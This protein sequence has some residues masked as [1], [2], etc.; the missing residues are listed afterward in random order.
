MAIAQ[1]GEQLADFKQKSAA[2][3][4]AGAWILHPSTRDFLAQ[5]EDSAGRTFTVR[6]DP[7][8]MGRVAVAPIWPI[9][10]DNTG[11]KITADPKAAGLMPAGHQPP[12]LTLAYAKEPEALAAD[13]AERFMPDFAPLF[14]ACRDYAAHRQGLAAG[15]LSAAA[16]LVQ[17]IGGRMEGAGSTATIF[18]RIG[19]R[20][21][22]APG[23]VRFEPF[24]VSTEG[25]HAILML[26]AQEAAEREERDR[27]G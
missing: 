24:S 20:V 10:T 9:W 17:R 1:A 6:L 19:P 27:A 22:L 13:I 23:V 7:V 15:V 26:I 11:K 5:L 2:L 21:D 25:A 16:Q 12:H 14:D 8:N 4:V 3:A 18:P